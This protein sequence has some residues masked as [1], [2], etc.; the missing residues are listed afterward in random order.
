MKVVFTILLCLFAGLTPLWA[1]SV[2]AVN[3]G[4]HAGGSLDQT[5]G[6]DAFGYTAKD[7]AAVGGPDY[8]WF[9]ISTSGTA[10]TGLGDD[11][12]VGPFPLGFTFHYYWY[13]VD[14]FWIGSNGYIK[15]SPT[16]QISSGGAGFPQFPD[17]TDPDDVIGAYVADWVFSDADPSQCHR[18]TNNDDTLIVSWSNIVA[19]VDGGPNEGNHNF[20]IIL[21]AVDSSI[22]FMYGAQTGARQ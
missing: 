22:T 1:A 2:S 5:W 9:D 15:F 7:T 17:A 10:V 12:V 6:P 16:G 11:N 20:Q 13:D 21:S 19:W 18:W 14:Q 3:P 4:H 8:R